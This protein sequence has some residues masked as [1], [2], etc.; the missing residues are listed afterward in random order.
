MNDPD[1]S[2]RILT[3]RD[4]VFAL[5][6]PASAE[7]YAANCAGPKESFARR[8]GTW[9]NYRKQVADPV[10][11]FLRRVTRLGA[12]PVLDVTLGR[13]GELFHQDFTVILLMAHWKNSGAIELADGF[14]EVPAVLD[15]I[16]PDAARI[17]DLSVCHPLAL[18]EAVL[19]ERPRCLT[20]YVD[21]EA[22][23]AVW[24]AF[25][26][27]VLHQLRHENLTYL[28]AVERVFLQMRRRNDG[29]KNRPRTEGLS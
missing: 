5:A 20:R 11:R 3:P 21:T 7:K 14:A 2:R 8:F 13:F 18:V 9:E 10:A 23:P 6:L 25:Y 16:P 29:S 24:L 4:C 19:R 27:L 17:L 1:L 12:T 15:E 22:T 28:Q 26:F